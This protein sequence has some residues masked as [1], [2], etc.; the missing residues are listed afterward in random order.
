MINYIFITFSYIKSSILHKHL[1]LLKLTNI[2]KQSYL[3]NVMI[4]VANATKS[5]L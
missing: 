4:A 5:N 1:N 3:I 2:L